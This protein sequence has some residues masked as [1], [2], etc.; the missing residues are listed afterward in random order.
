MINKDD[1]AIDVLS[2]EEGGV[3]DLFR[4]FTK[5]DEGDLTMSL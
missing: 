2:R 5:D 1:V 3:K 4:V